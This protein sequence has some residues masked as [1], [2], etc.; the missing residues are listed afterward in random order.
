MPGLSDAEGV[1]A[2]HAMMTAPGAAPG[3]LDGNPVRA[4][5]EE[6]AGLLGVDFLV[7]V[8]LNSRHQVVEAVAGD[9]HQAFRSGVAA[10]DRMYKVPVPARYDV[11]LASAGGYPKDIELYQAQ[12]A[13]T[14]ARRITREGGTIA[15]FAECREGHGSVEA[16]D[17]ARRADGPL[18]LVEQFACE[19]FAMGAHKAYQ[20]AR[21][22]CRA[23]IHLHSE[24]PA[25]VVRAFFMRPLERPEDVASLIRARDRVAVLPH[26][27]LT[28]PMVRGEGT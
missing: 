13:I 27:T 10:V 26:A 8:V 19:E 1:R 4:E 5:I 6:A 23:T 18:E 15:V 3:V 11:V 7:N 24:L 21:E 28:L 22:A 14:S 2:T 16:Y 25:G 20:I 17:R 12:K 9:V